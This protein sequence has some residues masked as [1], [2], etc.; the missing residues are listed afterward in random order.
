MVDNG[1]SPLPR[2]ARPYQG[3]RAGLV[4][5]MLA[6]G[7]DALVVGL[8]LLVGWVGWAVLLFLLDPRHFTFPEVGLLFSMASAFGVLVVYQGLAWWLT[9]RTYGSLV[10]GLRVVNRHGGRLNLV[11]AAARS[12]ACAAFPIGILWVAVSRHHRSLQDVALRTS[13]IY[14]WTPRTGER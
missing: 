10:M 4:T 8:L 1:I 5:R 11:G 13:V 6:A 3:M 12:L 9:G 2:E 7:L 14:D